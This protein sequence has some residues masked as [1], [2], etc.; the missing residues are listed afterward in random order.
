MSY[1]RI[2]M[3]FE[4]EGISEAEI[5]EHLKKNEFK[6]FKSYSRALS[7]IYL[8]EITEGKEELAPVS[9]EIHS[10]EGGGACRLC[11]WHNN[12]HPSDLLAN[13][14]NLALVEKL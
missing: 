4:N 2:I 9:V 8:D 14:P 3:D 5:I 11:I 10:H 6:V 12:Y 7:N 13:D 1:I